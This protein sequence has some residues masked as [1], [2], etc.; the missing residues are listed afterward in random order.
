MI[1]GYSELNTI[2]K[3]EIER[4]ENGQKSMEEVLPNMEKSINDILAKRK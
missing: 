1:T 4:A 3:N 2:I